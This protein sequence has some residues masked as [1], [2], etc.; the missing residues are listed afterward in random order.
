MYNCPQSDVDCHMLIWDTPYQ[1]QTS[2][3]K[4]LKFFPAPS[5]TLPQRVSH[6]TVREEVLYQ[7]SAG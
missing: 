6:N 4:V 5:S 2:L 3:H 1:F 7:V